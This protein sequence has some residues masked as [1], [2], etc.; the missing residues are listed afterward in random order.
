MEEEARDGEGLTALMR[1]CFE[2]AEDR[3]AVLLQAGAQANATMTGHGF[4]PLMF[5]VLSGTHTHTK[6]NQKK[7]KKQ[8]KP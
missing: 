2:G 1:A 8:I 3:C 7:Q 5:A 4:T 6:E